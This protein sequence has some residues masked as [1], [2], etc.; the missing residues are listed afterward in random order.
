MTSRRGAPD[1]YRLVGPVYD[2][3]GDVYSAGAIGRSKLAMLDATRIRPG[4]RCLFVGAGRGTDAIR[5]ARLGAAVTVVEVS[6]TMLR[7]FRDAVEA[8]KAG[9]PCPDITVIRGDVLVHD[10]LGRYDVVVLN[11]FLNVFD[12]PVMRRMLAHSISLAGPDGRIVIGDFS[13]PT[14]NWLSRSLFL[15]YWY[16]AMFTFWLT[17]GNALHRI[18][19]LETIVTEHGLEILEVK[20]FKLLGMDCCSSILCKRVDVMQPAD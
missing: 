13:Y 4:D 17:A 12:E 16:T 20:T 5:A 7:Q 2:F 18:Y 19:H 8:A 6:P 15:A 9:H 10:E 1:R 3:L 11:F 14:G